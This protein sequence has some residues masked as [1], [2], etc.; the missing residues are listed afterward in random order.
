MPQEEDG[1]LCDAKV[2]D[3]LVFARRG[4][5][6]GAIYVVGE[7]DARLRRR[8]DRDVHFSCKNDHE[9]ERREE[10]RREE[11]ILPEMHFFSS[12]YFSSPQ[13]FN[14]LNDPNRDLFLSLSRLLFAP[15]ASLSRNPLTRRRLAPEKD[16]LE[17]EKRG[18]RKRP[19]N[20]EKN[21]NMASSDNPFDSTPASRGGAYT[22][23]ES[24]MV[25]EALRTHRAT[26]Q[27]AERALKV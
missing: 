25:N 20:R 16:L 5:G 18:S 21:E 3:D 15:A 26:T 6:Q 14:W 27:A 4:D 2:D 12:S 13:N 8:E 9:R 1:A 17:R 22:A 11:R 24:V 7:E 19:N 23:E 10:K